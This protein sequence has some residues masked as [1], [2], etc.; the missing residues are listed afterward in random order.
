[1]FYTLILTGLGTD[2]SAGLFALR[3]FKDI[4]M[5]KTFL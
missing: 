2:G 3:I 1:M 5:S 4:K